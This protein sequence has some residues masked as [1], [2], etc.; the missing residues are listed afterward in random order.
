MDTFRQAGIALGVAALGA[1][2]PASAGLGAAD[3]S[4]FVDGLHTAL[5]A[6]AG[7][8]IVGAVASWMLIRTRRERDVVVPAQLAPETA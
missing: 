3:P 4:G 8:A 1:M 7:L 6:G 2:I 5:F